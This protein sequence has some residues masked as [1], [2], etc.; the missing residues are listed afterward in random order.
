MLADNAWVKVSTNS[1]GFVTNEGE[2]TESSRAIGT[3]VVT[4]NGYLNIRQEAGTDYK[5]VG[6]LARSDSVKVYEVKTVNGHRWGRI[7][8]GWICLTYTNFTAVDDANISDAGMK[9]YAY[10][11]QVKSQFVPK[12]AAGQHNN[13]VQITNYKDALETISIDVTD[14]EKNVTLTNLV[15]VNGEIWAKATWKNAETKWKDKEKGT[16]ETVYKTR[17][18]WIQLIDGQL[19]MDPVKYTVAADSVN[20]RA[21]QGDDAPWVFTLNKGTQ[22]EV[23]WLGLV[24]ENIWGRITVK[25][26]AESDSFGSQTGWINLA[27][28]YVTRDGV[29]TIEE[30]EANQLAGKMATVVGTDSLRV[31]KTGATYG[32]QIGRLSRGTTVAV[33]EYDDG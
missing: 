11:A 27:S 15:L 7:N 20:V 32:Q 21:F 29:P 1:S 10:T 28:K 24:G 9:L 3:A 19:A 13:P 26:T 23:N 18:G 14:T 8:S 30:E 16:T 25:K 2:I 17:S 5:I 12:V 22:V 31:R 6:A 33:W 4:V